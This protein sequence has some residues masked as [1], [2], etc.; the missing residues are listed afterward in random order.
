MNGSNPDSYFDDALTIRVP[1]AARMLGIG[2]TKLYELITAREIDVIKVGR[3]T[4]IVVRS[5]ERFVERQSV[6]AGARRRNVAGAQGIRLLGRAPGSALSWRDAEVGPDLHQIAP[7]S[8]EI[9]TPVGGL[10]LVCASAASAISRGTSVSSAIQ[11]LKLE[12]KPCTVADSSIPRSSSN[13]AI[14][15][16]V[17]PEAAPGKIRSQSLMRNARA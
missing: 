1:V 14:S 10:D 2:K 4:L 9:G 6:A 7:L 16:S 3:A 12:R 13:S 8:Q 15:E 11:S 5:L 17:A